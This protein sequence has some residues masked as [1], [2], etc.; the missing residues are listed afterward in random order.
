MSHVLHLHRLFE[1][2]PQLS[3]ARFGCLY[4]RPAEA[5][6]SGTCGPVAAVSLHL[7]LVLARAAFAPGLLQAV[8]CGIPEPPVQTADPTGAAWA[9]PTLGHTIQDLTHGIPIKS[10]IRSHSTSNF[11]FKGGL[12]EGGLRGSEGRRSLDLEEGAKGI[13][14][15]EGL[16]VQRSAKHA[17]GCLAEQTWLIQ[18]DTHLVACTYDSSSI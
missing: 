5:G 14:S 16:R 18:D 6:L 7:W 13:G 8:L 2:G 4:Q 1:K 9:L 12:V 10:C 15:M 17:L 11:R 3:L